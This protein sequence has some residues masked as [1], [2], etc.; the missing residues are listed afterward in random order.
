MF[1]SITI[2][3][4]QNGAKNRKIHRFHQSSLRCFRTL[5]QRRAFVFECVFPMQSTIDPIGIIEKA[6]EKQNESE[7]A[8]IVI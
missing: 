8:N 1:Q 3:D 6:S 5:Y 2:R 7:M 4:R